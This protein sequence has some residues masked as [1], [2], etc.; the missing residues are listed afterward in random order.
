ML[1]EDEIVRKLEEYAAAGDE[2]RRYGDEY[3][4]YGDE[5]SQLGTQ[6]SVLG[7][8][9]FELARV[10]SD[11]RDTLLRKQAELS[12]KIDKCDTVRRMI[13]RDLRDEFPF[14]DITVEFEI[15]GR[16]VTVTVYR[17]LTCDSVEIRGI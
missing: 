10:L 2:Y 1:T 13:V 16:R 12:A 14:K 8:C 5:L 3:R 11:K 17:G 9:S 6:D 7:P 15:S 4:R